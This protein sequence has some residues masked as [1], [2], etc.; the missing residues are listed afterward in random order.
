MREAGIS[1]H[2]KT[3]SKASALSLV[4]MWKWLASVFIASGESETFSSLAFEHSPVATLLS[5]SQGVI[6]EANLA[7]QELSG[8]TESELTGKNMSL[9][10]S[11]CYESEFYESFWKN[12]INGDRYEQEIY[13]RCKDN[14]VLLM[15]E[16]ISCIKKD[17][18]SYYIVTL[19]DITKQTQ[20]K[21]RHLYLATHDAVTGLENRAL[22]LEHFSH[23]IQ[24]SV[25]S[26]LSMGVLMCDINEFKSFN[27]TYGHN[28][29]D[30]ILQKVAKSLKERIG[31]NGMIFRYGG[32]EF[33]VILKDTKDSAEILETVEIITSEFPLMLEGY[34]ES[35]SVAISVGHACFP[36]DGTTADQLI[37]MADMRMYHEKK[38]YYGV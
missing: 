23:A 27:D 20:E 33:V 37:H 4:Q 8:Y 17:H 28:T 14:K 24:S 36:E 5:D 9:L 2:T 34:A 12:I 35:C 26:T 1:L 7:F 13:N 15:N 16:K 38:E 25:R 6:L 31:T 21:N 19:E 29:G 11:G 30:L 18:Y 22:F 32:D 3:L 10:Q